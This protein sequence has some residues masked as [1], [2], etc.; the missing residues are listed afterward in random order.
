MLSVGDRVS[1]SML[2]FLGNTPI[3]LCM[4][5][6]PSTWR[7]HLHIGI[8]LEGLLVSPKLPGLVVQPRYIRN[9][10]LRMMLYKLT[11]RTRLSDQSFRHGWQ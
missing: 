5:N 1:S 8:R 7:F 4:I 11:C 9:T 3:D 2:F 10:A 6:S